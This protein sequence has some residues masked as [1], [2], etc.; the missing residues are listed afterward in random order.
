MQSVM[1]K[2]TTTTAAVRS[3]A[4]CATIKTTVEIFCEFAKA[5]SLYFS[6]ATLTQLHIRVPL[7]AY[8]TVNSCLRT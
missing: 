2:A 7:C 5:K 4:I 6:L 3:I 8:N 1:P